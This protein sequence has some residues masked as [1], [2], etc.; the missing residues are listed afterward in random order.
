M[1]DFCG[2]FVHFGRDHSSGFHRQL[3]DSSVVREVR[4]NHVY[5]FWIDLIDK[6]ESIKARLRALYN[7]VLQ[8]LYLLTDRQ[9]ECLTREHEAEDHT[10]GTEASRVH[11]LAIKVMN[12]VGVDISGNRSK[13]LNEL[14]SLQFGVVITLCDQAGYPAYLESSNI[15]NNP[16]YERF[17]FEVTAE[18]TLPEDGPTM[19]LMERPAS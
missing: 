5:V 18:V 15:R 19:W 1:L 13:S 14:N 12:E 2:E 10:A 11:P 9:R 6:L 4:I 17:G 3:Y 16:L 8:H 7:K